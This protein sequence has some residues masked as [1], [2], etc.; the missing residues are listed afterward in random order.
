MSYMLTLA[1]TYVGLKPCGQLQLK[2]FQPTDGSGICI[3]GQ[4]LKASIPC[5]YFDLA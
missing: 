5:L 2:P 1:W 3:I 4:H